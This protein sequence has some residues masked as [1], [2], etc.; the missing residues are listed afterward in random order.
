MTAI[1]TDWRVIDGVATAWFDA[2]SLVEG[3]ALAG[4]IGEQSAEIFG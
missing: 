1:G 4:R 3:A 2:P